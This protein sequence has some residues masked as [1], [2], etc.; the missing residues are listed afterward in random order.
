MT[1]VNYDSIVH[2]GKHPDWFPVSSFP[3]RH[4]LFGLLLVKKC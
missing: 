3:A 2:T 4:R 1:M